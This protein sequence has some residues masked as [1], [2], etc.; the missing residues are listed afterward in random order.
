MLGGDAAG[1]PIDVHDVDEGNS[2]FENKTPPAIGMIDLHVR[3]PYLAH[4][5]RCFFCQIFGSWGTPLGAKINH[6]RD[7]RFILVRG[8]GKRVKAL[9]PV[10]T[11]VLLVFGE[12]VVTM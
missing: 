9:R 2:R 7:T 8:A 3:F 5:C 4:L 6:S 1:S 11:L 10:A 12:I